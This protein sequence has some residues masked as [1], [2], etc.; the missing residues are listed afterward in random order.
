M[1]SGDFDATGCVATTVTWRCWRGLWTENDANVASANWRH[2]TS[3]DMLRSAR[4]IRSEFDVHER[5]NGIVDGLTHEVNESMPAY[6]SF[7]RD[8]TSHTAL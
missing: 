2:R 5:Y 4:I 3:L 7:A 8:H 6:A 1:A